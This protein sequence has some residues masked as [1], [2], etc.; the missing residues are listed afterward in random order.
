MNGRR[1]WLDTETTGFD[2]NQDQILEFAAIA[3]E[4][5]VEVERLEIK[6]KLKQNVLPS[7]QALL[8]NQINPYSKKWCKEA[9]TENEAVEALCAF[10]KRH[11][12]QGIKPSLCAYNADFD[13][14][15]IA[16]TM[17]RNGKT[18]K[19]HFNRSSFD[20]L[21]TARSLVQAGKIKTKIKTYPGGRTSPSSSLEDVA[22]GLNVKY[23]GSAHRAMTDVEVMKEVSKK[24]FFL[25]T[26]KNLDE[27]S[28]KASEF[29]KGEVY[30]VISDSKR[31]GLKIRHLLIL[32]NDQENSR[33]VAIDEDDLKEKNGFDKS[34]VRKFNYGTLIG[35]LEKDSSVE[36]FLNK[37]KSQNEEKTEK[38]LKEAKAQLEQDE[39]KDFVFDGDV[40]D[41]TLIKKLQS[42]MQNATDKKATYQ[43]L[44]TELKTRLEEKKAL[45]L[46][47]KAEA[48]HC[49][50]GLKAW[51][52]ESE[53]GIKLEVF[54]SEGFELR[55]GLHP[56]GHY[57]LG[58]VY[59]KSGKTHKELK[60]I[61]N[62]KDL[63][64][65]LN[66]K[67]SASS[68]LEA[69]IKSLPEAEEFKN[70][71]A[72]FVLEQNLKSAL[73]ALKVKDHSLEQK[74]ALL[75]LLNH[76]KTA[77]PLTFQK[78][79][80]DL[81]E[82]ALKKENQ[83]EFWA[84]GE[85][86]KAPSDPEDS[87][88]GP[89]SDGGSVGGP[90]GL[91]AFSPSVQESS[92]LE[93]NGDKK[94]LHS[95][96]LEMDHLRP[97][98]RLSKRPCALCGRPLSASLS[99]EASMGPTCRK[100]LE[101]IEKGQMPLSELRENYKSYHM[102][103]SPGDLAALKVK[104]LNKEILAEFVQ[105]D[106]ESTKVLDRKRLKTL[107]EAGIQPALAVFLSLLNLSSKDIGGIARL[108]PKE[109]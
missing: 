15:M 68:E 99:I 39:S 80:L 14:D 89:G 37:I 70:L 4:N 83:E 107:I 49:A 104:A 87:G 26:E 3:E 60:D 22:E 38:L 95:A 65:F 90:G 102:R 50:L 18:F 1:I 75:G 9:L 10:L 64:P 81:G 17:A 33:L 84:A 5:G 11:E 86:K 53:N 71:K 40:K 78:Y 45:S 57:A 92:S 28:I 91:S 42:R 36:I 44:L 35:V 63:L 103:H 29:K 66:K 85:E 96:V 16:A 54:K 24:L 25:A 73:D 72:P 6:F 106:R 88:S 31:S 105:V 2:P 76:L 27:Q 109:S 47:K 7:P 61:K 8:I 23:N 30:K 19:D 82:E 55:V 108:K 69:F 46:L 62:K 59:E 56:L 43:A 101:D 41:F 93:E 94:E 12:K 20:P 21:Q 32:D 34:T 74:A 79:K 51:G 13:K 58:V 100:H 77:H 98:E 67:T 97:G 48:L 52:L